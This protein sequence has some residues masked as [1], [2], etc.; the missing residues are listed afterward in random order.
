MI[1]TWYGEYNQATSW[2]LPSK[3]I[4][5]VSSLDPC[6][7]FSFHILPSSVHPTGFSFC[8]FSSFLAIFILLPSNNKCKQNRTTDVNKSLEKLS[9]E[10]RCRSISHA[11]KAVHKNVGKC[12][13]ISFIMKYNVEIVWFTIFLLKFLYTR[14]DVQ[15]EEERTSQFPV[16]H[17]EKYSSYSSW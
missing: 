12:N 6:L 5:V 16:S 10:I 1:S 2:E 11:I 9:C 8:F 17:A 3:T 4:P 7:I 13:C 14:T 15:R